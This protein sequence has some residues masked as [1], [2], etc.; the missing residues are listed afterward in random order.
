MKFSWKWLKRHWETNLYK[1]TEIIEN[2]K[3]LSEKIGLELEEWSFVNSIYCVE[4][5]TCN[6][7]EGTK[8]SLC[9]ISLHEE[10]IQV[11]CGA[12]NCKA[13]M[14]TIFA[15]IGTKIANIILEKKKIN[16]YES[17]GMF[18]S[19]K[20]LEQI[21]LEN[22]EKS[23]NSCAQ[24]GIIQCQEEGIYGWNDI[25]L[26]FSVPTNRWD[27]KSVRG[28]SQNF[29]IWL[30]N[31][32]PLPVY[33]GPKSENITVNNKLNIPIGFML[34]ENFQIS[35]EIKYFMNLIDKKTN[36]LQSLNDFIMI[37]IGIPIHI[38]DRNLFGERITFN[39]TQLQEGENFTTLKEKFT[40]TGEEILI[41]SEKPL[42]IGGIIGI[43]GY[44]SNTKNCIIEC[45]FWSKQHLTSLITESARINYLEPDKTINCLSYIGT[46]IK[47]T[48]APQFFG[49]LEDIKNNF[50]IESTDLFKFT[51]ET[52]SLKETVKILEKMQYKCEIAEIKNPETIN[53][54]FVL[55]V[56]F[57]TWKK[58][59]EMDILEDICKYIGYDKLYKNNK[60]LKAHQTILSKEGFLRSFLS[61][62]GYHEVILMP[63]TNYGEIEIINPFNKQK[64][65]LQSTPISNLIE[66][67]EEIFHTGAQEVKLFA[68][69]KSFPLE[70]YKLAVI[71]YGKEIQYYFDKSKADLWNIWKNEIFHLK[72][73]LY[74]NEQ[75]MKENELFAFGLE[76]KEGLIGKI[77]NK[78]CFYFE[79]ELNWSNRKDILQEKYNT[80][81]LSLEG[82]FTWQT[83]KEAINVYENQGVIFELFDKFENSWKIR[84]KLPIDKIELIANI[85]K[86]LADLTRDQYYL[87]KKSF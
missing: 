46:L 59:D 86:S 44:N 36:D 84:A 4:I 14:K 9:T 21:N 87:E 3:N 22:I 37:D 13:G 68:V 63:F 77:K 57:P 80:E 62:K 20:E 53:N 24:E 60:A 65:F 85:K 71:F 67:A 16:N 54:L 74:W 61:S 26:N 72:N 19:H 30:G 11:V 18:L 23:I 49:I 70:Q 8:L 2:I 81:I 56:N 52:I 75:S 31:I 12:S 47:S 40:A 45:A 5:K 33:I 83:I 38:Y 78:N 27:F 41:S 35:E 73:F 10:E 79:T 6:K 48:F 42:C 82:N 15:P 58:G 55:K 25:L 69:E 39:L 51:G 64:N 50:I 17:C 76:W 66:K 43:E 28:I 1:S 32:L 29:S 7:I 34:V